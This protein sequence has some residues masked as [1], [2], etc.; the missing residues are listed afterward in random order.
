MFETDVNSSYAWM[1]NM[2][3]VSVGKQ[4]ALGVTYDVY[5]IV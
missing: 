4:E 1:N 5:Q 2:V 3:S